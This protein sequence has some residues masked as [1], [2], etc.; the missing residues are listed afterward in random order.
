M[1]F[2]V[3]TILVQILCVVHLIR[4]N[5]NSLWLWAIILLP[6]AGSAAYLVVEVL[7][8]LGRR[9]E[10]R[11]V[12][13]AAIR[14]LDPDRNLRA[15]RDALDTANTAANHS[16]LGDALGETGAWGEAAVHYRHAL[17]RMPAGDRPSQVKL[18]RALLESGDGAGARKILEALPVSASQTENDRTALLLA[19][20][21]QL[22]GAIDQALALYS[23]VGARMAGA[24]AQCRQAALLIEEGRRGEAVAPLEEVERRTKRLGR[25]ERASASDMYDWADRTLA[26]LR[27]G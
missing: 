13:A 26:E 11:A 24:E 16:A 2:L 22:C 15:A 4:N 12:K 8:G 20:S 1:G 21:L 23:E 14:K 9:R 10:V 6:I 7:P 18:A 17:D 19:R 3:V 27:Q 25:F 5:R